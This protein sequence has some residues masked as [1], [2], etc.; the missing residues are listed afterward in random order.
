MLQ[1]AEIG[2]DE[3][4]IYDNIVMDTEISKPA[5]TTEETDEY[6]DMRSS[7]CPEKPITPSTSVQKNVW[8]QWVTVALGV[9]CVLLTLLTTG[10]C[11]KYTTERDQLKIEQN[12]LK[13]ERDQLKT[14]RDQLKTERDQLKTDGDLFKSRWSNV[15]QERDQLLSSNSNLMRER[16]QL[17]DII[18]QVPCPKGWNVY[19]KC[20][21]ISSPEKP[22]SEARQVCQAMGADLVTI[23]SEEEQVYING[24]GRWGWIG[25]QR[26]GMNWTW[27]NDRPLSEGP[28]FWEPGQPNSNTENCVLSSPNVENPT[29]NWHDYPCSS[30]FYPI[31]EKS[32]N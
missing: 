19:S 23:E 9:L 5:S 4:A 18:D 29:S 3:E 28:V 32:A 31:C 8:L 17:Q 10:L 16:D 24:L 27:V 6:V 30:M 15:T 7:R 2:M 1:T 11:V 26:S 22:W 12:Q 20:Y 21:L 25:L 14:E 13:T